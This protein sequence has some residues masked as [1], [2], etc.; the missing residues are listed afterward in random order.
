MFAGGACALATGNTLM[1]NTTII[2][3]ALGATFLAQAEGETAATAGTAPSSMLLTAL[4]ERLDF[5]CHPETLKPILLEINIVW[6]A[7]FAVLGIMCVTHGYQWRKWIIVALAALAGMWGASQLADDVQGAQFMAASI[8]VITGVVAWPLMRYAA[9]LFGGLAGGFA[10][11]N[12]WTA[13]GQAPEQH[14][15]GALLGLVIVSMLALTAFR[16]VII[17][18]T[19]IVGATMFI[20]GAIAL[21]LAINMWRDGL[22]TT[23]ENT[24]MLVPILI[25]STMVVGAVWQFGGGYKGLNTMAD[26]ANGPIG[27]KPAEAKA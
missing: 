11:A 6:A 23:I 8:A 21:L 19:S 14:Y 3:L 18:L 4:R 17:A 9:A 13:I 27:K 26:R 22:L 1:L 7:I 10:G 5:L 16:S 12:I 25:G 20:M 2:P 24:P 15:V